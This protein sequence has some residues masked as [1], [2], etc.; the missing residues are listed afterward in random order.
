MILELLVTAVLL[1][2]PPPP[3]T[4]AY[5]PTAGGSGA[6]IGSTAPPIN[7]ACPTGR[8]AQWLTLT[9]NAM[10]QSVCSACMPVTPTPDLNAWMTLQPTS[11]MPIIGTPGTP[12]Q[13]VTPTI[14]PTATRTPAPAC[15]DTNT[16]T[17]RSEI[18][19]TNNPWGANIASGTSTAVR[20]SSGLSVF[21]Y[22]WNWADTD[23]CTFDPEGYA[24][25]YI[26]GRSSDTHWYWKYVYDKGCANTGGGWVCTTATP[27]YGDFVSYNQ[28]GSFLIRSAV[29]GA[30]TG[31]VHGTLYVSLLNNIDCLISQTNAIPTPTP[32]PT[33]ANTNYCQIVN[34]GSAYDKKAEFPD[35][36]SID[37]TNYQ[38]YISPGFN[39]GELVGAISWV[40]PST[41]STWVNTV[42][43]PG[44]TVCVF[45]VVLGVITVFGYQVDLAVLFTIMITVLIVKHFISK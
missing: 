43:F 22:T 36:I 40:L 13:T 31:P 28:G 9:P 17:A 7:T 44:S 24:R 32:S 21:S 30:Y 5:T 8:P 23:C 42:S 16:Y 34:G 18:S 4:P 29:G 15:A 38:C 11:S 14:A 2:T 25:S 35:I 45:S 6:G 41:L 1:L 26:D 39:L 33:P 10:W 19:W 37:R 3:G 27:I 20:L 12:T